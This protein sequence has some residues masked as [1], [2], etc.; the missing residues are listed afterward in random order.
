MGGALA[1][2]AAARLAYEEKNTSIQGIY[3]Y[4]QPLVGDAVFK[5]HFDQ[6]FPKKMYRVTNLFDPITLVPLQMWRFDHVGEIVLFDEQGRRVEKASFWV[7]VY[8]P[9]YKMYVAS[10]AFAKKKTDVGKK[11]LAELLAPHALEVYR[12]NI[13][14]NMS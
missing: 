7:R 6:A 2:L 11:K 8:L 10:V 5:V 13:E 14:E 1:T 4:G 3:T 12:E 9:I